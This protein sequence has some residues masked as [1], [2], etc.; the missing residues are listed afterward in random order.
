[1]L[2]SHF[3]EQTDRASGLS[4]EPRRSRPSGASIDSD[5]G[6]G[7]RSEES[8]SNSSNAIFRILSESGKASESFMHQLSNFRNRSA[9]IA[10]GRS[11]M[12]R[13]SLEE[14]FELSNRLRQVALENAIRRRGFSALNLS[15]MLISQE[16]RQTTTPRSL[17]TS[18]RCFFLGTKH[19][20]PHLETVLMSFLSLRKLFPSSPL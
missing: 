15:L 9:I 11:W 1:M 19:L 6:S 20:E 14:R 12:R 18:E 7:V 16:N 4:L 5:G 2:Q 17:N 8:I 10:L 3:G 13:V